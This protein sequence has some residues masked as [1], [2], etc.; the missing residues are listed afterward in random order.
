MTPRAL[1]D[2]N[3]DGTF[4][5]PS[6]DLENFG[7]AQGWVS[8]NTFQRQIGDVNGDGYPGVLAFGNSA[9]F[10]AISNGYFIM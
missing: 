4:T 7:L 5:D 2:V 6:L 1:A 3:G 10:I 8:N 9:T